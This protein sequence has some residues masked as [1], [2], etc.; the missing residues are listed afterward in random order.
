ML[1]QVYKIDSNGLIEEILVKDFDEQGNC[2]EELTEDIITVDPPQGLYRAKWT[3]SE[4][5]ETMTEEEYIATLPEQPEREL[6]EIDK[7]RL[8]QAQSNAEM[9][10]LML[11]MIGGM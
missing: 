5:I 9:I 6:S 10:D 8:E 3:G 4:W 7:L 11:M 1:K 2:V